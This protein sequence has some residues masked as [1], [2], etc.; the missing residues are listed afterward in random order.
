MTNMVGAGVATIVVA[1]WENEFDAAKAVAVLNGAAIEP[2][3]PKPSPASSAE[4]I[5]TVA[6]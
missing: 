3:E 4:D 1:R 5:Q 6:E 2:P